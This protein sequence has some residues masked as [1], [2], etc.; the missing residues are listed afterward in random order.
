MFASPQPNSNLGKGR[1]VMLLLLLAA[2][3]TA[4]TLISLI[5]ETETNFQDL[6][7]LLL[8]GVAAAIAIALAFTVVRLRV[9]DK[10]PQIS[11]FISIATKD[12]ED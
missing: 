4:F 8:G 12:K 9:R 11:P 5:Q 1:D 7:K 3:P 10:R 6:G 2:W